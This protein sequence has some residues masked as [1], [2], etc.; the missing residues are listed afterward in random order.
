MKSFVKR[1][2]LPGDLEGEALDNLIRDG[3]PS[4]LHRQDGAGRPLG[5]CDIIGSR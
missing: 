5:R 4:D 2:I 1:E 3:A